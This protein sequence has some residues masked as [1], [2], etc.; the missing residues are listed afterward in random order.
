MFRYLATEDL[1][2]TTGVELWRLGNAMLF[3]FRRFVLCITL[4]GFSLT[5]NMA[6]AKVEIPIIAKK[7]VEEFFLMMGSLSITLL[8]IKMRDGL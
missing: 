7:Q 3:K 6:S 1:L 8:F 5:C 2:K 4:L